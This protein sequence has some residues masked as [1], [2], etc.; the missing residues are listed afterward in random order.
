MLLPVVFVAV[1]FMAWR[2]EGL[3]SRTEKKM[4]IIAARQLEILALNTELKER[5]LAR[6]LTL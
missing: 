6:L 5:H 3:A 1:P 4:E 2:I